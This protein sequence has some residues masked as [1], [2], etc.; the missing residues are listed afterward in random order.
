ML[1]SAIETSY[2]LSKNLL[3][4][5]WILKLIV[6]MVN[7]STPPDKWIFCI[8]ELLDNLWF[9]LNALLESKGSRQKKNIIGYF[10][11]GFYPWP[12]GLNGHMSKNISFFFMYTKL[13][14]ETRNFRKFQK[15]IPPR[16]KY[17]FLPDK[18]V[19]PL[20]P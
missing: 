5:P 13:V 3:L 17:I 2:H 6:D 19:A 12:P 14:F 11:W 20:H 8:A 15:K 4:L 7:D 10:R 16:T 18:G 9:S 1:D